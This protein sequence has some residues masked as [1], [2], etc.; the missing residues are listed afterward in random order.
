M[1]IKGH[2]NAAVYLSPQNRKFKMCCQP[3]KTQQICKTCR[4]ANS[5]DDD[6]LHRISPFQGPVPLLSTATCNNAVATHPVQL[7]K[8]ALMTRCAT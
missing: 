7:S 1:I 8:T 6:N 2:I 3:D 5:I 4:E